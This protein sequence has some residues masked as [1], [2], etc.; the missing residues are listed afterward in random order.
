MDCILSLYSDSFFPQNSISSMIIHTWHE[1]KCKFNSMFNSLCIIL[2]SFYAFVL[3]IY[4]FI[5]FFFF[6]AFHC[7]I[8]CIFA[9]TR[10]I[11][12]RKVCPNTAMCYKD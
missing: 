3:N 10:F 5:L 1:Y 6:L 11:L 2:F 12:Y 7:S 4:V 8:C 9:F